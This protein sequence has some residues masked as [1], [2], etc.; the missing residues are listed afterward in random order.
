MDNRKETIDRLVSLGIE[1]TKANE[2]NLRGAYLW[3]ADLQCTDLR[4]ASLRGAYL[5]GADL[6]GADLQD[7]DLQSAYLQGA[8]LWCTD[9]RGANLRGANL[10]GAN[11]WGADLQ[12]VRNVTMSHDITAE[13]LK[14]NAETNN[15]VMYFAGVVLLMREWCWTDF[16]KLAHIDFVLDDLKAILFADKAWGYEIKYNETLQE[17]NQKRKPF[18]LYVE[19]EFYDGEPIV[20]KPEDF[21]NAHHE[22]CPLS[23]CTCPTCESVRRAEEKVVKTDYGYHYYPADYSEGGGY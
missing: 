7:A 21:A 15:R 23:A 2:L 1:E 5:Q 8:D 22:L 18:D 17:V 6:K 20:L 4:G 11:L 12:G 3:G 14:R 19:P 16:V 10:Q 9:L 13:I